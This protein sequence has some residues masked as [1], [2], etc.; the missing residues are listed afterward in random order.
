MKHTAEPL[1]EIIEQIPLLK[2]VLMK[3]N[4]EVY[5][6]TDDPNSM[7]YIDRVSRSICEQFLEKFVMSKDDLGQRTAFKWIF[8]R[9]GEI[10]CWY[11]L[12]WKRCDEGKCS[13]GEFALRLI[14]N[15]E[16][17]NFAKWWDQCGHQYYQKQ[18]PGI[19]L[20]YVYNGVEPF[21]CVLFYPGDRSQPDFCLINTDTKEKLRLI[22]FKDKAKIG[23]GTYKKDDL[24][25]YSKSEIPVDIITVFY[26]ELGKPWYYSIINNIE[27]LL[28]KKLKNGTEQ[29]LC[30]WKC[31]WIG[32]VATV[33]RDYE[34]KDV[35]DG[36]PFWVRKHSQFGNMYSYKTNQ[37]LDDFYNPK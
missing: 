7:W 13:L 14:D 6:L 30:F 35:K 33:L 26:D 4:K 9:I 24:L 21:P 1:S 34:G 37:L 16:M 2:N 22:E 29:E 25:G 32:H 27:G 19:N 17:V 23:Q 5:L 36:V 31:P 20:G 3:F 10:K 8:D 15:Q 11:Q 18:Y 12:V 28:S